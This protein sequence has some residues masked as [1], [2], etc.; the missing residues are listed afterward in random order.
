MPILECYC[1]RAPFNDEVEDVYYDGFDKPYIYDHAL[2]KVQ[3]LAEELAADPETFFKDK[4]KL[5]FLT[6]FLESI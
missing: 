2:D 3:D 1:C 5:R 4:E 6:E